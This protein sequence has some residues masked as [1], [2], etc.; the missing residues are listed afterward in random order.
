M[1]KLLLPIVTLSALY[2][3]SIE[4]GHGNFKIK[5]KLYNKQA[6]ASTNIKTYSLVE[7]HKNIFQTSYYYRYNLSWMKLDRFTTPEQ[8]IQPPFPTINMPSISHDIEGFDATVGIGKD[9]YHKTEHDYVGVGIDL[10]ISIPYSNSKQKSNG[11][12]DLKNFKIDITTYKIG[13]H[14][15]FSK[16][17]NSYLSFF[18]TANYCFQTFRFKS[19]VLRSSIDVN[20]QSYSLDVGIRLDLLHKDYE[21]K[22]LT[23]KPRL[24]GVIGYR[25]QKWDVDDITVKLL[26]FSEPLQFEDMNFRSSYLYGGIGYSF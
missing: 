13:P 10:G 4:Y 8:S 12:F 23:I 22:L 18:G 25:Y 2:A 7:Q 9:L 5:Y 3:G 6:S 20:G 26:T 15:T 19:S 1:K 17:F 24:Y 11:S 14:I 21:T 16:S